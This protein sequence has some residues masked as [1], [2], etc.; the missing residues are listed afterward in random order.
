MDITVNGLNE[1][2]NTLTL[3]A[4]TLNRDQQ[5]LS[6][7]QLGFID[8]A[9]KMLKDT[10]YNLKNTPQGI[11]VAFF[12]KAKNQA[13]A[14]GAKLPVDEAQEAVEAKLAIIVVNKLKPL[15]K[16]YLLHLF[17]EAR[18]YA[19]TVSNNLDQTLPSEREI[20]DPLKNAAYSKIKLKIEKVQGLYQHL[21]DNTSFSDRVSH[22]QGA[23]IACQNDLQEQ[24]DPSWKRYFRACVTTLL[25]LI[26]GVVPGILGLAV[27]SSATKRSS[28]FQSCGADFA[29]DASYY[30]AAAQRP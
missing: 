22:F 16:Q 15:T 26:T 4:G 9:G 2:Y 30:T 19:P 20:N 23:L 24:R 21:I 5:E 25:I 8:L 18:K 28:F 17:Q 12:T 10:S 6:L 13:I 11:D 7:W 14:R 3:L 27:Y 1:S 29:N